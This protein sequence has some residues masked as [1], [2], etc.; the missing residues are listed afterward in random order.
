M[1]LSFYRGLT[2]AAEPLIRFYL[3]RRRAAGK[4]DADRLAERFGEP[5]RPRPAGALAWVHGASVGESLSA[6]AFIERVLAERPGFSVLVTTGTVTSA[7]LLESRLPRRAFHQYVPV[8]HAGWIQRFLDHWRPDL[9]LWLESELWPN[10]IQGVADAQIPL[11]L[12][13]GRM[14][15]ASFLRWKRVPFLIRP[16]LGHFALCLGQDEEQTGRLSALGAP[17]ALSVGNLKF[18]AAPLPVDEG[19]LGRLRR[20]IGDRP[21]WLAASTHPGEEALAARVH[22]AVA[23]AQP[24]LLT[25]VVP[26]HADRGEAIAAELAGEGHRVARRSAGDAIDGADIYLADTMGE[27]GLFYRLAEVVFVGKSLLHAGGHNP[28]EPAQ[29]GCA[30]VVGPQMH[31]FAE[32]VDRLRAGGALTEVAD[33]AGLAAGVA[34]LLADPARR[35]ALARAGRTVA[36]AEAGVL[37]AVLREIQPWLDAAQRRHARGANGSAPNGADGHGA[38]GQGADGHGIGHDTGFRARS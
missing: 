22:R 1:T 21:C 37:D 2:S 29:L 13:N 12:L 34:A 38:D 9:A 33:E 28:L 32:M 15:E 8:D 36:E 11:V 24:G 7:R 16:L 6:L 19:A 18:A 23:P 17:K 3:E 25:I 35:G 20:E 10:L 4:E 27:L 30:V 5:S 14:S 26:R 31:N